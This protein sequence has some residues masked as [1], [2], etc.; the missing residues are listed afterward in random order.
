MN[1]DEVIQT[2]KNIKKT[3]GNAPCYLIG[4]G[5]ASDTLDHIKVYGTNKVIFFNKKD[6]WTQRK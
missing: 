5:V 2:L 3:Y 1:I 6:D 4:D